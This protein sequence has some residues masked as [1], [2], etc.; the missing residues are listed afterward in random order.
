MSPKCHGEILF[1]LWEALSSSHVTLFSSHGASLYALPLENVNFGI[2]L[3]WIFGNGDDSGH[4]LVMLQ[5]LLL[6]SHLLKH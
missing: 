6:G 3:E 5:L 2:H 1:L 4:L